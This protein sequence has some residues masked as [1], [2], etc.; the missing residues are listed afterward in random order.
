MKTILLTLT[1]WLL[2]AT[3]FTRIT[4]TPGI[5]PTLH[6]IAPGD[7]GNVGRAAE[8]DVRVSDMPITALNWDSAT[9]MW[10][11]PVPSVSGTAQQYTVEGLEPGTEYF[12]AIKTADEVQNWSLLSN[13]ISYT[14]PCG[15][16]TTDLMRY[17]HDCSGIV[18]ISDLVDMIDYMFGEPQ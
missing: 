8:Y 2:A 5:S 18:D 17:D 9:Q 3:S 15:C 6:W 10:G 7:D 13:V 11:E 12:F 16:D 4:L 14:T 1:I